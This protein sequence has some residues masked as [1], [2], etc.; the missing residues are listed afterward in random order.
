MINAGREITG[1][2]LMIFINFVLIQN[3]RVRIFQSGEDHYF[4]SP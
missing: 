2:H 3:T 4:G 1:D